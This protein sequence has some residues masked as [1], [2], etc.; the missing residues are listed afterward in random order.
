MSLVLGFERASQV[1]AGAIIAYISISVTSN[2]QLESSNS[3][4]GFPSSH[5][6]L[7]LRHVRQPVVVRVVNFRPANF[8]FRGRLPSF[9]ISIT[10]VQVPCGNLLN[11]SWGG[12]SYVR[13]L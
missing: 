9:T 8:G 10:V 11:T 5:F 2:T 4:L 13:I 1:F 12:H 6:F 3:H 7:R